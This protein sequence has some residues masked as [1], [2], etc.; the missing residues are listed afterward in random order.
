MKIERN[1]LRYNDIGRFEVFDLCALPGSLIDICEEGCKIKYNF[2]V[3]VDLDNEYQAKITFARSVDKGQY[4]LLC[5]PRWV[6]H[7]GDSTEIGFQILPSAD[8]QNLS[9][10][11][12]QLQKDL[13][14]DFSEN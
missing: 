7:N 6:N 11:I 3:N 1:F 4:K 10:Y 14:T 12:E 9:K 2:P 5:K 8:F 13:N